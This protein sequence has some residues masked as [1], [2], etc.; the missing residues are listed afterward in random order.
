MAD[1]NR[2]VGPGLYSAAEARWWPRTWHKLCITCYRIVI[3]FNSTLNLECDICSLCAHVNKLIISSHL[4]LLTTMVIDGLVPHN[5][6]DGLPLQR[7]AILHGKMS[8]SA[9][10]SRS[11]PS[12]KNVCI[13]NLHITIHSIKN[14]DKS[15]GPYGRFNYQ[16]FKR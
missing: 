1:S 12:H 2:T 8:G 4:V 14:K 3:H 11:Y 16:T 13:G 6:L 5:P 15:S 10:F 7:D 9:G